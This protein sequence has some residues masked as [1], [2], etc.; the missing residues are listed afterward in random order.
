MPVDRHLL[1]AIDAGTRFAPGFSVELANT[2]MD[3]RGWPDEAPL[4]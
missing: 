2:L 1:P 4:A 3:H